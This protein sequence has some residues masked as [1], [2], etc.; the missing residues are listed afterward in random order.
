MSEIK[1]DYEIRHSI[2]RSNFYNSNVFKSVSF[3]RF[4]RSTSTTYDLAVIG[5][6]PGG[7]VAAIKASQ[8]GLKVQKLISLQTACIEKNSTL[9]GTCLNIGCIPSKALLHSSHYY[10][11]ATSGKLSNFGIECKRNC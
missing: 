5:S 9:G 7:Y 3:K 4:S 8:L 1:L 6:G 10:H 2:M 11:L